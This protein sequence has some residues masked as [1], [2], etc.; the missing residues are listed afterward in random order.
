[1]FKKMITLMMVFALFTVHANAASQ[2]NLKAAFDEL[3]YSLTVE[4]DQKDK[5]FYNNQM[6]KFRGTLRELQRDGLSNSELIEF[7]KSEVKDQRI[8]RDL[9]TA[10]NMVTI[11]KMNQEEASKYMLETMKKSYSS[12]ASWGGEVLIYLGL[13]LLV[14]G[15]AVALSSS[16]GGSSSSSGGG[17]Y[18]QDY[19]VCSTDCY[20]DPYWGYTCVDDCYWTCY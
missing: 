4:W 6:K 14:V 7:V 9:E 18:C 11:N 15:V 20:Y 5:D 3:N 12:G 10:F 17:Y 19:Q 8:A 2:N 16:G 1:V 13:G